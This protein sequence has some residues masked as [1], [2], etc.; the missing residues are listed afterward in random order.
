MRI[1]ALDIG[2]KG[3]F[4]KNYGSTKT[5]KIDCTRGSKQSYGASLDKLYDFLLKDGIANGTPDLIA[6]EVLIGRGG[7]AKLLMG[8]GAI[9]EFYAW[10][11]KIPVVTVPPKTLKKWATGDGEA[12][13]GDM[14]K[15]AKKRDDNQADACLLLEYMLELKGLKQ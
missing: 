1:L 15:R 7:G 9:V 13:K 6:H 8:F 14:K 4:A 10:S 2:K 12:N 5:G 3:A 11:R